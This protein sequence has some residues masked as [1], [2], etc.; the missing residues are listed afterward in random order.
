MINKFNQFIK[1]YK[2][3]KI[4]SEQEL[5]EMANVSSK[6]T[7]I[8][9]IVLWIGPNPNSHWKRIK[10]SNVPNKFDGKDC[11]TL[12]I[13]DFRIIGK[14]NKSLIKKDVMDKIIHFVELNIDIISDYSD[15]KME[16]IDMINSLKKV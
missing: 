10:V 4:L 1:E 8:D 13:P 12:T 15:Y 3:N 5:L 14:I 11:F 2:E 6:V 9:D 7:G 16:T